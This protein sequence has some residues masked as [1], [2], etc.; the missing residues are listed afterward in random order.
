MALS[1]H[2]CVLLN[3]LALIKRGIRLAFTAVASTFRTGKRQIVIATN[4][5]HRIAGS[6]IRLKSEI[7]SKVPRK[8]LEIL[9]DN[10]IVENRPALVIRSVVGIPVI[11]LV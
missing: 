7:H 8:L 2:H 9:L 3:R 5:F 10:P 1:A 6:E 11:S 4:T